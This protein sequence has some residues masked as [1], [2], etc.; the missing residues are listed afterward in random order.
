MNNIRKRSSDDP[1]LPQD[2]RAKHELSRLFILRPLPPAFSSP[3][4]R[5]SPRAKQSG[6]S[7]P[8]HRT[9]TSVPTSPLHTR[10]EIVGLPTNPPAKVLKAGKDF[11]AVGGYATRD[12]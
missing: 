10:N 9:V 7:G 6:A 2:K 12:R 3:A 4:N 11:A 1:P 8:A 5:S